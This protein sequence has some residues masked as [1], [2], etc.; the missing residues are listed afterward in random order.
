MIRTE[1]RSYRSWAC[2]RLQGVKTDTGNTDRDSFSGGRVPLVGRERELEEL[3][4]RWRSGTRALSVVGAPGVGKSSVLRRFVSALSSADLRLIDLAPIRDRGGFVAALAESLNANPT[5]SFE[6]LLRQWNAGDVLVLDPVE[7]LQMEIAPL[8]ERMVVARSVRVL[9]ASRCPLGLSG[10]SLLRLEPLPI[11]DAERPLDSTAGQLFRRLVGRD[12][13]GRSLPLGGDEVDAIIRAVEGL[14]LALEIAAAQLRHLSPRDVLRRLRQE[15]VAIQGPG[16]ERQRSLTAAVSSSLDLLSDDCREVLSAASLFAGT[17]AREALESVCR[18]PVWQHLETLVSA[19]LARVDGD[20]YALYDF[21]RQCVRQ[22][23]VSPATK[24]RFVHYYR[25]RATHWL[26]T[27]LSE[28]ETA[29]ALRFERGNLEAAVGWAAW[30][31]ESCEPLTLA[32]E[33]SYADVGAHDVRQDILDGAPSSPATHR[34]RIRLC[35]ERSSFDAARALL[36]E[37][38]ALALPEA[39]RL[40]YQAQ[41]DILSGKPDVGRT[42]LERARGH[43]AP[44]VAAQIEVE[45]GRAAVSRGQRREAES[46]FASARE[47]ARNIGDARLEILAL[48]WLCDTCQQLQREEWQRY[49]EVL[50]RSP[51]VTR[52]RSLELRREMVFATAALDEDRLDSAEERLERARTIAVRLPDDPMTVILHAAEGDLAWLRGDRRAARDAWQRAVHQAFERG[53][54]RWGA[55]LSMPLCL[56]QAQLGAHRVATDTFHAAKRCA[57]SVDD[58][59]LELGFRTVQD[60]LAEPSETARCIDELRASTLFGE[61]QRL[62]FLAKLLRDSGPASSTWCFDAQRGSV[63]T[64]DGHT[65]ELGGKK[66]L[67]RLALYLAERHSPD[68]FDSV[69]HDALIEA[70][71]PEE[72]LDVAAARNRLNFALVQLRRLGF[73]PLLLREPG[74]YRFD[75][76]Q[77]ITWST[78]AD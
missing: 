18:R 48:T 70:G 59:A 65:I 17:F 77:T 13:I 66:T 73:R 16:P 8:L 4:S 64:P 45:L 62:R 40:L 43:A 15:Y 67:R 50:E 56:V 3:S 53:M 60:A 11:A 25:D 38:I 51:W 63:E 58:P 71:W 9:A 35:L 31:P 26:E 2:A 19:S 7:H 68:V 29:D 42:R 1:V 76:E 22:L 34:A 20:R 52:S 30:D 5:P 49:A 57:E 54:H 33:R 72:K 27:W 55:T 23:G 36:A 78:R 10:E 39:E 24:Q 37:R 69:S 44:H 32:W 21:V 6:A 12:R 46:L 74:G 61:T 41:A 75:P 28:P 14:P 47:H